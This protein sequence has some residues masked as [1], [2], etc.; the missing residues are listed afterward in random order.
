MAVCHAHT[1]SYGFQVRNRAGSA[2]GLI[3]LE[4]KEEE[5]EV[6]QERTSVESHPVKVDMFGEHVAE[7]HA[8]NNSS[9]VAQFQVS[10]GSFFACSQY[11][12]PVISP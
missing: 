6:E 9:F 5:E 8:S 4:V 1:S 12:M 3:T 2:E 10:N 7:M 11:T